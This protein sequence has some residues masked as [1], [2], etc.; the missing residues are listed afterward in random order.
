MVSARPNAQTKHLEAE[1]TMIA[2]NK[3]TLLIALSLPLLCAVAGCHNV[4]FDQ[5]VGSAPS[6][7]IDQNGLRMNGLGANGVGFNNI[8]L[9]G[10]ELNGPGARK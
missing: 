6:A 2:N 8:N 5:P 10:L 9:N 4:D 7:L 3:P 1:N